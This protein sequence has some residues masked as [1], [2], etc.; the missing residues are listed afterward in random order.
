VLKQDINF[1]NH[2]IQA[3]DLL[4]GFTELL[5]SSYKF[6]FHYRNKRYLEFFFIKTFVKY[7]TKTFFKVLNELFINFIK[8]AKLFPV[9]FS[10]TN[11]ELSTTLNIKYFIF[12]NKYISLASEFNTVINLQLRLDPFIMYFQTFLLKKYLFSNLFKIIN[13]FKFYV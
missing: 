5:P 11:G 1:N 4:V 10:I 8:R 12:F 3:L 2:V 6:Y 13:N 7:K 9:H